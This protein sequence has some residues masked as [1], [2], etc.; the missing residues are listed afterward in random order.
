MHIKDHNDAMTFFRNSKQLESNG[1]W[2][3]FVEES[4]FDDMLQEP[5]TMA[6]GGRIGFVGGNIVVGKKNTDVED[7]FGVRAVRSPADKIPGATKFT[8][9][10]VYFKKK[11]DAENFKKTPPK[12][13]MKPGATPSNDPKRLK[14]TW[15]II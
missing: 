6:H 8:D 14:N 10:W 3:E 5:R 4:K 9:E 11:K 7:L 2:K 1:K 13:T 15:K 12:V